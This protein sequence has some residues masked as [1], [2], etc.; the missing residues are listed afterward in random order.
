MR[1]LSRLGHLLEAAS[2]KGL[3][4]ELQIARGMQEASLDD[5]RAPGVKGKRSRTQEE[6]GR[7]TCLRQSQDPGSPSPG[8]P[9][10]AGLA[11]EAQGG[12]VLLVLGPTWGDC[13]S[14]GTGPATLP[15]TAQLV[16]SVDPRPHP[17]HHPPSDSLQQINLY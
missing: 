5:T 15:H 3:A 1:T 4:R 9:R 16:S 7:G 10:G 17:L 11:Q 2:A 8:C 14:F 6:R 12:T 13:N